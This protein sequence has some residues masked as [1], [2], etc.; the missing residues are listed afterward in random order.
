MVVG[1]QSHDPA[2]L[3]PVKRPGTRCTGGWVVATAGL[4]GYGK[5]RP[6]RDSMPDLSSP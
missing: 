5:S 3:T 4:D 6:R 2:V 1:G